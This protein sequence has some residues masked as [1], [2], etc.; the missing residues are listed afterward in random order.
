MLSGS[1]A[2]AHVPLPPAGLLFHWLRGRPGPVVWQV[3]ASDAAMV[4][5]ALAL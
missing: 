3:L 4:T 1:Y 5:L 2:Y